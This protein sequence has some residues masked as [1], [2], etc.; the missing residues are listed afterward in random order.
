[1]NKLSIW[2]EAQ[3]KP[4][5]VVRDLSGYAPAGLVYESLLR[6][7]VFKWLAVRRDLIRLKNTWKERV[8]ASLERQRALSG[9]DV[10][11]ER[12]YRKAVEECRAEV[13]ALCHSERWRAPDCDKAAQEWLSR[14]GGERSA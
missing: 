7:G 12:G 8:N 2:N 6:R 14:R 13:R 1:M 4:T 10:N 9:P 11:Y 3:N 5:L